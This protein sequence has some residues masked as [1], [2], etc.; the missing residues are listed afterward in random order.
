MPNTNALLLLGLGLAALTMFRRDQTDA[1]ETD[2]VDASM[3]SSGTGRTGM[4]LE[5][6]PT[7][8]SDLPINTTGRVVSTSNGTAGV[9]GFDWQAWFRNLGV[10]APPPTERSPV[11]NEDLKNETTGPAAQ[12]EVTPYVQ[13]P[14]Y[15]RTTGELAGTAVRQ[16]GISLGDQIDLINPK[17]YVQEIQVEDDETIRME[18]PLTMTEDVH[19]VAGGANPGDPYF[20]TLD[21]LAA[22]RD[23]GWFDPPKEELANEAGFIVGA[24][25][26]FDVAAYEAYQAPIQENLTQTGGIPLQVS[27]RRSP[28]DLTTRPWDR[29]YYDMDTQM[30]F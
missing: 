12:V 16:L 2:L 14:E 19:I 3:L 5:A 20:T 23:Q 15:I 10:V 17:I 13:T 1:D 9:V 28:Y 29:T 21:V 11:V 30:E 27:S 24:S 25:N 22:A 6:I 18:Q 4:A 7:V 26:V 8:N